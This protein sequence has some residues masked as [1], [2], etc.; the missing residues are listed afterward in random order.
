LLGLLLGGAGLIV[1]LSEGGRPIGEWARAFNLRDRRIGFP[2]AGAVLNGAALIL[3]LLIAIGAKG[4]F[5]GA[6]APSGLEF[7]VTESRMQELPKTKK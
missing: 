1:A 3:T 2:F 7:N 5:S 6:R 4:V